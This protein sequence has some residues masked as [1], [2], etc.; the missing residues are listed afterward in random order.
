ML[1]R[2]G[3]NL[4]IL[5]FGERA[6]RG[7]VSTTTAEARPPPILPHAHTQTPLKHVFP[8]NFPEKFGGTIFGVS[9][10]GKKSQKKKATLLI[11]C[12]CISQ[13]PR[14][15]TDK[16][17]DK[18]AKRLI[19]EDT[20]LLLMHRG[21]IDMQM[22]LTYLQGEITFRESGEEAVR[23]MR[24]KDFLLRTQPSGPHIRLLR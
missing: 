8:R 22:V 15:M 11:R 7:D 18:Y 4:T 14:K 23:V 16:E 10:G 13:P 17:P 6:K 19:E 24:M 9:L 2:S 5:L 21:Y 1:N 20:A 3:H 12:R